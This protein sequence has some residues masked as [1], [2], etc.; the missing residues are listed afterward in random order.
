M[1]DCSPD[2]RLQQEMFCHRQW[3]DEYVERP[4]TLMRQNVE[5]LVSIFLCVLLTLKADK[6][7]AEHF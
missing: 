6:S 4:E 5:M 7:Q 2:E 3:T 1:E